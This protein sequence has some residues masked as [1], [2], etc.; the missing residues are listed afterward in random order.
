[1]K[2][3]IAKE[4]DIQKSWYV[5]DAKDKILGK[6]RRD[7]RDGGQQ[8]HHPEHRFDQRKSTMFP[9]STPN[10]TKPGCLVPELTSAAWQS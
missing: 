8:E 2:T 9:H 4:K 5:V 1:M 7:E 6:D 10:N 3:Y